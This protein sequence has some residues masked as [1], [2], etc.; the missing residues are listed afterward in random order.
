MK[1][2]VAKYVLLDT[3]FWIGLLDPRDG[4][5]HVA[6]ELYKEIETSYAVVPWPTLYEFMGTALTKR[7]EQVARLAA[8]L[9]SPGIERVNDCPY[10]ERALE[11]CFHRDATNRPMSLVDRVLRHMVEDTSIRLHA[12]VTFNPG[13]FEDVCRSRHVELL[14]PGEQRYW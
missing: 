11:A 2:L 7:R 6:N 9:L 5:H 1:G 10:R 12:V 14:T 8:L 4:K 3:G 13:D